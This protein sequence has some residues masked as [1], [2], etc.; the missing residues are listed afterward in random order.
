MI[1]NI[2]LKDTF[3]YARAMIKSTITEKLLGSYETA[4][5]FEL[6]RFKPDGITTQLVNGNRNVTVCW[7]NTDRVFQKDS[8]TAKSD[9]LNNLELLVLYDGD[10]DRE[11]ELVAKTIKLDLSDLK[12]SI[13]NKGGVNNVRITGIEIAEDTH[14]GSGTEDE[15]NA[16]KVAAIFEYE[17]DSFD[18]FSEDPEPDGI[19]GTVGVFA[20]ERGEGGNEPVRPSFLTQKHFKDHYYIARGDGEIRRSSIESVAWTDKLELAITADVDYKPNND[21]NSVE[22]RVWRASFDNFANGYVNAVDP[23][24]DWDN[25]V[26]AAVENVEKDDNKGN[27][28]V[29]RKGKQLV[30][31]NTNDLHRLDTNLG[32]LDVS[33]YAF[34]ETDGNKV[35]VVNYDDDGQAKITKFCLGKDY[36]Q[37]EEIISDYIYPNRV[38]GLKVKDNIAVVD[39]GW[40]Y[41]RVIDIENDE[42]IHNGVSY[43]K[44]L[45]LLVKEDLGSKDIYLLKDDYY[46]GAKQINWA[47]FVRTS[48]V[49]PD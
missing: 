17:D 5:N 9:P 49:K 38:A 48:S 47:G 34:V 42:L 15:S 18:E 43:D 20:V 41:Y 35:Y 26:V 12:R 39:M 19:R 23:L 3:N 25:Q 14:D 37:R 24:S 22:K 13:G 44:F 21:I 2:S 1:E 32:V 4:Y 36:L 11:P 7:R 28:L 6:G 31:H 33:E 27:L 10:G 45:E 8:K 46:T 16:L 30:F 29:I 40:G